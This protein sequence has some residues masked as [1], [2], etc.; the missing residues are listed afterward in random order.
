MLSHWSLGRGAGGDGQGS[1][2]RGDSRMRLE[3]RW[4]EWG[5]CRA[6]AEVKMHR[7][8]T[9]REIGCAFIG[10]KAPVWRGGSLGSREQAAQGHKRIE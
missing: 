8:G 10:Q 1:W 2:G 6:P 3:L 4:Q 7:A 5:L 9:L